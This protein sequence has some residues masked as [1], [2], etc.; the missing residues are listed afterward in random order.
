MCIFL[1]ETGHDSVRAIDWRELPVHSSSAAKNH[2]GPAARRRARVVL[3]RTDPRAEHPIERR[4]LP[5]QIRLALRLDAA[6]VRTPPARRP[7]A[8]VRMKPVDHIHAA[9]D[10][11]ERREA[12]RI[13]PRVVRQVDEE[14]DRARARA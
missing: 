13:E 14:L 5:L 6:L 1:P 12:G 3:R 10:A 2:W 4:E 9:R 7:L 11:A 8:E